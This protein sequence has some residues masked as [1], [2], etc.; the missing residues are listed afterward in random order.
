MVEFN[1]FNELSKR[2]VEVRLAS[3]INP[4]KRLFLEQNFDIQR[5][6]GWST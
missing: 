2:Y 3:E 1:I 4:K 5:H 6:L